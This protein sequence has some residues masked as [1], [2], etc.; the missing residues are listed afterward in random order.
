MAAPLEQ[1]R[2]LIGAVDGTFSREHLRSSLFAEGVP[3]GAL[4][5]ITGR[6][7]AGKTEFVLRLLAENPALNIA[8][9]ER[10]QSVYPCAFPQCGVDLSRVLFIEAGGEFVWAAMQIVRSRLF[11]VVVLSRT[12]SAVRSDFNEK[13]LRRLQ[14]AAEQSHTAVI[15]LAPQVRARAQ[16]SWPISLQLEV[17]RAQKRF[18]IDVRRRRYA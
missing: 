17:A 16:E 8:W 12:S 5:E 18:S 15:L 6:E 9:M 7:G 13:I 2:A 11:E 14:L 3:L 4:T 10:E 1:L